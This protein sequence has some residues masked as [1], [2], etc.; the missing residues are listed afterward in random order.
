M[1]HRFAS[2]LLVDERGWLLLQERDENPVIDPGCWGFVGGH[3]DE[4]EEPD[5]AA[6]RE[7]GR[8]D[9]AAHRAAGAAAVA[10][11]HHLPRGLRHPR[12][13]PRVRRRDDRH[14]RRHRAR[15][16]PA[17]RVRRPGGSRR[18]AAD[19]GGE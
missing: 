3:V 15:R 19:R 12:P 14:R 11:V 2:V 1:S 17:D 8:G 7:P 9:R 10:G 18:P 6:Y 16:G 4:G 5:A 13:G